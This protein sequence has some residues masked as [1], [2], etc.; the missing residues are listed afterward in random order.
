MPANEGTH[1]HAQGVSRSSQCCAGGISTRI[2][3]FLISSAVASGPFSSSPRTWYGLGPSME[4]MLAAAGRARV[5]IKQSRINQLQLWLRGIGF[6]CR[7]VSQLSLHTRDSTL[8]IPSWVG[9][10]AVSE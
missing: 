3:T 1:T 8:Q 6:T 5:V 2:F 4:S 9:G 7:G 10:L